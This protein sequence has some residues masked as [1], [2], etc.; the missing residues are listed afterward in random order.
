MDCTSVD[1][2]VFKY[3]GELSNIRFID[4]RG[5]HLLTSKIKNYIDRLA[6]LI[7]IDL[8]GCKNLDEEDTNTILDVIFDKRQTTGSL[9]E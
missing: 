1:D 7:Q 4:A 3:I 6:Y 5:C 9:N 2:R 8:R